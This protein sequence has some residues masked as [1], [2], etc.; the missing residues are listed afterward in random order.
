MKD[1]LP[2]KHSYHFLHE[3]GE[4]SKSELVVVVPPQNESLKLGILI[5]SWG[6]GQGSMFHPTLSMVV[7][8][9]AYNVTD[10]F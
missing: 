9:M 6:W 3:I 5:Q 1:M 7:V 8:V 2:T 4:T 10:L